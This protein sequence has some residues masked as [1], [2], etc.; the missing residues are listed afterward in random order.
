MVVGKERLLMYVILV[1]DIVTDDAGKKI[2]P[3][4]FKICKKYLTHIQHSVFEGNINTPKIT[5]LK[6]ELKQFIR[7]D[8]DSVI[9]F[10]SHDERW[11]KKE[12]IGLNDDKTSRFI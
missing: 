3:K 10:S 7:K 9:L 5:A 2:L 1:Y 4:V 11:L 6:N 8:V 12:F